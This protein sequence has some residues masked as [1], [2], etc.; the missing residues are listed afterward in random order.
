MPVT[1]AQLQTQTAQLQAQMESF[2]KSIS[3]SITEFQKTSEA[4]QNK[5]VENIEGIN[6]R[7]LDVETKVEEIEEAHDALIATVEE[8]KVSSSNE[9]KVLVERI[10]VLENKV[11]TLEQLPGRVKKL[12]EVC[13]ERTNRQLRETL[14]FRNVPETVENE[15]YGQT[16]ELL[17]Q[18]ISENCDLEFDDVIREIKRAH[19]ESNRRNGEEHY[20]KGK[21]H[22]FAAFHSWDLC[23]KIIETFRLKCIRNPEFIIAADQKY[24]PL[25]TRRRSLALKTRKELKQ[26]GVIAGGY[27]DFPAKLMVNYDGQV[28]N[29]RKKVYRLHTNF[30]SYDF[31]E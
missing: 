18:L 22:I 8:N 12:S 11:A 7:L 31:D 23:Q 9:I 15:S 3:D 21:R 17:A 27:I 30:S 4:N 10:A 13:E 6:K 25:T 29:D 2:Q 16:K 5:I 20:R 28:D 14:V 1:N 24:G 26:N 19:R